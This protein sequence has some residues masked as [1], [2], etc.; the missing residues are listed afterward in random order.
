MLSLVDVSLWD[1]VAFS[2]PCSDDSHKE[3]KY[4]E[5]SGQNY[6]ASQT[7]PS[8]LHML[9]SNS[10]FSSDDSEYW[11]ASTDAILP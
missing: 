7:I 2:R 3:Q 10:T 5:H 8:S 6:L 1:L 4:S 9:H 11:P